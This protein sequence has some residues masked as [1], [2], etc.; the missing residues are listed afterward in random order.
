MLP[1]ICF[2]HIAHLNLLWSCS[3]FSYLRLG[4]FVPTLLTR[5][6]LASHSHLAIR[7]HSFLLLICVSVCRGRIWQRGQNWWPV[8]I[9]SLLCM[10]SCIYVF[11][12]HFSQLCLKRERQGRADTKENGLPVGHHAALR[13]FS[14]P[15]LQKRRMKEAV[16]WRGYYKDRLY[17]WKE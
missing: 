16:N 12:P 6:F 10:W 2:L 9:I 13:P 7:Q 5:F 11:I 1:P 4:L 14:T 3:L 15:F 17:V 8:K